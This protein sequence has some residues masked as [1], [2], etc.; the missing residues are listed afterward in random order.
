MLGDVR[1]SNDSDAKK[2]N[3]SKSSTSTL[4][5]TNTNYKNDL[6]RG[7]TKVVKSKRINAIEIQGWSLW[8]FSPD[9]FARLMVKD[10][11]ENPYFEQFIMSL[12]ALN[13]IFLALE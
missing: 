13:S 8:L 7:D 12:I 1:K 4:K 2:S 11:V 10:L 3:D 5:R 9:N 6:K